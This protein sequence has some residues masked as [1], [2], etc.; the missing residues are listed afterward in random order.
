MLIAILLPLCA[1][2]A[3]VSEINI[4]KVQSYRLY[5]LKQLQN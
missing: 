1:S 2:L 4:I 3:F 5:I